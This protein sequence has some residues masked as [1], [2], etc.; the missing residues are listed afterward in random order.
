MERLWAPWR[1]GYVQS[2]KRSGCIFC[3]KA[4]AN[5]D[6]RTL[7]V[8][9][10][11][12]SF[13]LLNAY[14]YTNGHLM[15]APYEHVARLEDL[16]AEQ[17]GDLMVLAQKCVAALRRAL[18]PD[19]FNVGLNLGRAAGAGIEDHLHLHVVPRWEGDTS[20]TAVF[21]DTKVIAQSLDDAYATIVEA[22]GT[23]E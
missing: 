6:R 17:C 1:I 9:R 7:V 20:F 5:D 23:P 19:G 22:L 11:R 21:S 16:S 8:A 12:L 2:H 13:A 4:K 3:E 15:I 10:G 18:F 14:P